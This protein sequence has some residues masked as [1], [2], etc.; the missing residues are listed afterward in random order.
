MDAINAV[1]WQ[2]WAEGQREVNGANEFSVVDKVAGKS[3]DG[4]GAGNERGEVEAGN[5][6][7][8]DDVNQSQ[9]ADK[10]SPE[11]NGGG[12]GQWGAVEVDW[13][14]HHNDSGVVWRI[15]WWLVG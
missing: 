10:E 6:D 15:S 12:P 4:G 11:A 7:D 1:P 9:E 14:P 13:K 3:W 2:T 5:G 8:Q